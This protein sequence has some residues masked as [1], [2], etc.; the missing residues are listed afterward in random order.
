M[1]GSA[2]D[3]AENGTADE[4]AT[5]RDELNRFRCRQPRLLSRHSRSA[6]LLNERLLVQE[7]SSS[8]EGKAWIT[9]AEEV[10]E[11]ARTKRAEDKDLHVS[12]FREGSSRRASSDCRPMLTET[13]SPT[14]EHLVS[15]SDVP[16]FLFLPFSITDPRAGR[17]RNDECRI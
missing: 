7:V 8:F 6:R 13:N 10:E 1:L 3:R 4:E 11:A 16:P 9:T 12:C 2:L 15:L 14:R 5:N 17:I